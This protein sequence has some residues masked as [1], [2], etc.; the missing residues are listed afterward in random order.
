[1]KTNSYR[2]MFLNFWSICEPRRTYSKF[3]IYTRSLN[4]KVTNLRKKNYL[5]KR[6]AAINHSLGTSFCLSV[7]EVGLNSTS[8]QQSHQMHASFLLVVCT[9]LMATS[10]WS[11]L[12][13]ATHHSKGKFLISS[14]GRSRSSSL[15]SLHNNQTPSQIGDHQ[16]Q[17]TSSSLF[18]YRKILF[19]EF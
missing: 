18:L 17:E 13:I 8:M 3:R 1:M 4:E 7:L 14:L 9:I 12:T 5:E 11:P 10:F 6:L 15:G 16:R 19:M 2:K